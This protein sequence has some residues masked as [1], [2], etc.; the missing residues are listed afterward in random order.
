MR[1]RG[2]EKIDE[3]E[4]Y[5]VIGRR[6]GKPPILLYLDQHSGRSPL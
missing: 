1:M 4:T 2:T 3:H 6:E 5:E